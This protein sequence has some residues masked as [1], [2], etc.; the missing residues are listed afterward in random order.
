MVP[1]YPKPPR[2]DLV[3]VLHGVDVADPFRAL[4]ADGPS[5]RAWIEEENELTSAHISSIPV[6]A[7]LRARIA[8]LWDHPKRGVPF[9]RGGRWFQ[10][11]NS[12]LQAQSVLYVAD[13]P[14]AEGR[15]LIDPNALSEDGI[16]SLTGMGVSADG[17]KVAW[18]TSRA[19]SDWMTWRVRHVEGGDDT[20]DVIEWSRYSEA[21]WDGDGF[22]YISF[23]PPTP[24]EELTASVSRPRV[25]Y[26]RT[27]TAQSADRIEWEAPDQQ[28]WMPQVGTTDDGRYLVVTVTRGTGTETLVM[29]RDLTDPGSVLTPLNDPFEAKDEVIDHGGEGRFYVLTDRGAERGRVVRA[30]VGSE[31]ARWEEIVPESGDTLLA[32][33]LYGGHLVCHY[34]RHAQSVLRVFAPDGTPAGSVDLPGPASVGETSGRAGSPVV[35]LQLTSYVQSGAI[36]QHDLAEGVTR[37][38]TP[39]AAPLEPSDYLTEQ[40][41]VTS[42]D[43]SEVPMFLTHRVGA[44]PS[45]DVPVLLYGYGGFN[46]ALTPTFSVTFAS[47][48]DRGGLLAVANL[49]GGGEYGRAW[50]EAGRLAHKQNVFDDFA[51]CARWLVSSGWSRPSSIAIM[52]G[53]NGGLLVG[54]TI[55]QHPELVG[56]ALAEV[57]VMDM[58]RFH[59][60]TI[61]RAWKSDYGDPDDPEQF[62]WLRAYSPLHNIRDGVCY[63]ATL[64]MTGDHDDRVVPAHS[65]KFAARL[66]EAQSCEHPVLLR[67]TASGGHGAGKPTSM[68]IDEAAD[69]LA[70]LADALDH[71]DRP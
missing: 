19:G 59:L 32:A 62:A 57:G 14:A 39:S 37:L 22:Y 36:W 42:P 31:P 35:H 1:T 45:G 8:E 44:H 47:W 65:F 49:R 29:V 53:S 71:R 10:F 28:D 23:D 30:R 6:W 46:V 12:G 55:T 56:A 48:L 18:A 60:F 21:A 34:L 17:T 25:A 9:E 7:G 13:A 67:V 61:G 26:H 4:E 11:R 2:S 52:G 69:R 68:L 70:F 41:F 63:P 5:T 54:A 15:V 24:G 40:V 51:A 64:V 38:V 27:G 33:H 20:S 50:H 66:Q 16:V 58:L 3:E 43:G